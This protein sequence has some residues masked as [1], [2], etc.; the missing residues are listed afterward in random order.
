MMD[1]SQNSNSKGFSNLVTQDLLYCLP[2]YFDIIAVRA[3]TDSHS[4]IE[5]L[6]RL[7][8]SFGLAFVA[9]YSFI[10]VVGFATAN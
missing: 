7:C 4:T 9:N 2:D 3:I 6:E 1:S 8:Y 10:M 5:H